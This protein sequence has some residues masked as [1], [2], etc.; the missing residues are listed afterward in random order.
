MLA[1]LLDLFLAAALLGIFYHWVWK[2]HSK[3][4]KK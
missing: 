1:D 4:N 3:N 2:A